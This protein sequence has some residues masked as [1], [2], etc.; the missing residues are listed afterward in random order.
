[1]RVRDIIFAQSNSCERVRD[2]I[3]AQSNSCEKKSVL[4]FLWYDVVFFIYLF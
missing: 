3:F 2:L 4:N 1:M